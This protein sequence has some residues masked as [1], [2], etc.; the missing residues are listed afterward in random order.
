[1]DTV[2]QRLVADLTD[3]AEA[4]MADG[5]TPPDRAAV[6]ATVARRRRTRRLRVGLATAAVTLVVAGAVAALVGGDG[7][8][9]TETGPADTTVPTAPPPTTPERPTTTI[10]TPGTTTSSTPPGTTEAPPDTPTT[11]PNDPEAPGDLPALQPVT[12][13]EVLA[14]GANFDALPPTCAAYWV[15][16]VGG[17]PEDQGFR[18]T[19]NLIE[20]EP[21][22]VTIAD[23]NG[24]GVDDGVANYTCVTSGTIPPGGVVVM[25][26][27]PGE[28]GTERQVLFDRND[29]TAEHEAQ[30]G[31]GR[32]RISAAPTVVRTG[33][34]ELLVEVDLLSYRQA[35]PHCCAS[36]RAV[37]QFGLAGDALQLV[38]LNQA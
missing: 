21:G 35:D 13:Q 24:D 32:T 3:A 9:Q 7:K 18:R 15:D 11:P 26:A 14:I 28:Q 22:A 27:V 1:M 25:L 31:D 2:E 16:G 33:E 8:D 20:I 6:A 5:L 4:A 17:A 34:G 29:L 10:G 30:F 19:Q 12:N 37:A 36:Q 38:N 23:V